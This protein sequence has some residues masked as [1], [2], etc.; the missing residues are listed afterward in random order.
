MKKS[1]IGFIAI[2]A[3]LFMSLG[4]SA[5]TYP[6]KLWL[7]GSFD[8]GNNWNPQAGLLMTT[9][10]DGVYTATITVSA[11]GTNFGI[12]SVQSSDW[13][14]V[15]A[16]RWG[17]ATDNA[18]LTIGTANAIV[19]GAGAIRF[20]ETGTFDITVDLTKLTI[21]AK[22]QQGGEVVVTYPDNM[23]MIGTVG[24]V[25]NGVTQSNVGWDPSNNTFTAAGENGVYTFN[26]SFKID[27]GDG[28][29]Y[30][31]FS[32]SLGSNSSD[33]GPF[34]NNRYAPSS[35]D[36]ELNSG[37]EAPISKNV[38][39]SDSYKLVAGWYKQIIIDLV[40]GTICAEMQSSSVESLN[41]VAAKV[42]GGNGVINISGNAAD[43]LV[44][45]FAGQLVSRTA[46]QT[47][48]VPAGA[49][50]V[51]VDGKATKVIVK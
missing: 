23:Y 49:Y 45:T 29:G 22:K 3:V 11:V 40:N 2:F 36:Y 38:G 34:N 51:K 25:V 20:A 19:K 32:S 47:I 43:I 4:M 39:S 5:Q 42:V 30:I 8:N 10:S 44:Y 41:T 27:N 28:Y 6:E 18:E 7:I 13:N 46:Q 14:T 12:V 1:L 26:G 37:D 21:L 17:F 9:E 16:N 48:A 50:I 31:G 24:K 35:N 33:W 15:N